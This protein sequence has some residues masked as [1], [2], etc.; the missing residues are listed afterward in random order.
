MV[1]ALFKPARLASV[2]TSWGGPNVGLFAVTNEGST[3]S[4]FAPEKKNEKIS[5]KKEKERNGKEKRKERKQ[6]KQKKLTNNEKQR[7]EPKSA[8]LD[9]I[10]KWH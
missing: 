1:N 8:K 4:T 7:E 10:K 9:E 2:P 3:N 5:K 6:E